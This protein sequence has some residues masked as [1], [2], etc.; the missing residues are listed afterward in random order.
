MILLL[1]ATKREIQN[2]PAEWNLAPTERVLGRGTWARADAVLAETGIGITNAAAV[3]ALMLERHGPDLVLQFGIGG[4][5]D[6][7]LCPVGS[8]AWATEEAYADLGVETPGELH[9]IERLGFPLGPG[10]FDVVP[11]ADGQ[12]RHFAHQYGGVCGRFLTVGTV[13]GT[14]ATA[15]RLMARWTPL[16]ENM[17]G[18]AAAHV[19]ALAGVPFVEV[20]G[21][22]N[23]V[24][25]RGRNPWEFDKAIA[26]VAAIIAQILRETTR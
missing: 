18:A 17:E 5:F 20:R 11:V 7:E 1:A 3:T 9:A 24:E 19:C 8:V 22:S 12:A 4:T 13:T 2:L 26:A 6:A 14:D 23:I 16:C 10:F 25:D 21:V 15:A